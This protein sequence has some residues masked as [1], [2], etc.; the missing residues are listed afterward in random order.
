MCFCAGF[1]VLS[2]L[3]SCKVAVFAAIF[4]LLG[5]SAVANDWV[6]NLSDRGF[7]TSPAGS[8]VKYQLTVSTTTENNPENALTVVIPED[9]LLLGF[10]EGGDITCDGVTI[11]KGGLLGEAIFECNVPTLATEADSASTKLLVKYLSQGSYTVSATLNGTDDEAGNN[12]AS[13]TTTVLMGTDLSVSMSGPYATTLPAGS[14]ATFVATAENLG[15]D[16]TSSGVLTFRVPTGLANVVVPAGCSRSVDIIECELPDGFA[17]GDQEAFTFTGQIADIPEAIVTPIAEVTTDDPKDGVPENNTATWDVTVS[18]GTDVA[19]TKARNPATAEIIQGSP[20]TFTLGASYTGQ[21]PGPVTITDTVPSMHTIQS[22]S[23][24]GWN[25]SIAGQTVTCTLTPSG[26]TGSNVSLGSVEIVTT[27]D[28]LGT[29]INTATVSVSGNPEDQ[30]ESN[31]TATDG[32]ASVVEPYIDLAASLT[33][34]KTALM[35]VG[36][37][38]EY[39]MGTSNIGNVPYFGTATIDFTVP[40]DMTLQNLTPAGWTCSPAAPIVGAATLTCTQEFTEADP[41][42]VNAATDRVSF[43]LVASQPTEYQPEMLVTAGPNPNIPEKETDLGNNSL[44]FPVAGQVSTVSADLRVVKTASLPTLVSGEIQT[45]DIQVINAG[46]D[47]VQNVIVTDVLKNLINN[48]EGAIDAG[49]IG[50][51]FTTPNGI[52]IS[53]NSALS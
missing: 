26:D 11:P 36:Q 6:V 43:D 7:S 39:T 46:P 5:T 51:T 47:P 48:S 12:S 44:I 38:Y 10:G 42:G 3:Q 49:Y 41:L 22:A 34:P 33:G 24:D 25:C 28:N 20:V 32:G 4:A 14:T 15:P 53:C 35:T 9:G 13:S 30:V 40:A 17:Q 45:F 37:P 27:A 29:D 16:P 31:N 19:L 52:D 1:A 2:W 50:T 21:T 23:G 18:T 8:V